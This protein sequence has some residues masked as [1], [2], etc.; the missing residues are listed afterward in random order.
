MNK[1]LI[2][3]KQ[4]QAAKI[5]QEQDIDMWMTFV[6]ESGNIKDPALETIV[7]TG[8]TWHSAII[9][10]KNADPIAIIGS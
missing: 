9:I 2:L 4:A 1:E 6:R 7:G 10:T 3:E 8:A 5:L